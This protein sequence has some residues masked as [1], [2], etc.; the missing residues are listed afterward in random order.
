MSKQDEVVL[1]ELAAWSALSAARAVYDDAARSARL[2]LTAT[3]RARR[4]PLSPK[5]GAKI[6]IVEARLRAKRAEMAAANQV[7]NDLYV[8]WQAALTAKLALTK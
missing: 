5:S 2:A 1:A 3:T 8:A 4:A 6:E 7:A